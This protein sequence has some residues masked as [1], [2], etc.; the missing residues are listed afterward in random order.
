[1]AYRKAVEGLKAMGENIGEV[2]GECYKKEI[3]LTIKRQLIQF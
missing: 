2:V 3:A 1:M